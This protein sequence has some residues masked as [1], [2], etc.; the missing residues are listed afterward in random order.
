MPSSLRP[1]HWG[2]AMTLYEPASSEQLLVGLALVLAVFGG[3]AV[4][5]L[6]GE[7]HR[8]HQWE[9]LW[10]AREDGI[11]MA[12]HKMRSDDTP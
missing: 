1:R 6:Y 12:F 7:L 10:V 4:G 9:T 11:R 3:F 5:F 8:D 2:D